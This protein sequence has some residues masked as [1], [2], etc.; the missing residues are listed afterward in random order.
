MT[1]NL[2]RGTVLEPAQMDML[3]DRI[4]D[5]ILSRALWEHLGSPGTGGQFEYNDHLWM[6]GGMARYGEDKIKLRVRKV[7]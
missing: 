1:D 3:N 4:G 2:W 5:M 6:C 7:A